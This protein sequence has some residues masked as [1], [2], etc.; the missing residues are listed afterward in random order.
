[1]QYFIVAKKSTTCRLASLVCLALVFCA[2]LI[3]IDVFAQDLRCAFCG[4]PIAPNTR[5]IRSGSNTFCSDACFNAWAAKSAQRCVVCGNPIT[6]GY[7]KDGK[8]YCSMKC[9]STTFPK[10]VVC[11]KRSIKGVLIEGD[12]SKFVCQE[13]AQK[14]KC[15]SCGMPGDTKRMDDGRFI[16]QTCAK[17]AIYNYSNAEEIFN[18]VRTLLREKLELSTKHPIVMSLVGLDRLSKMSG[19]SPGEGMEMGLFDYSGILETHVTGEMDSHGNMRKL[20]ES[21]QRVDES[22]KI[23]VLYGLPEARLGEVF[24]HELAHDWMQEFCPNI[25]DLKLKEG[26]AEYIAWKMNSIMGNSSLNS[27]IEKNPDPIY[28]DGFRMM[29]KIAD[30]DGFDGLKLYLHKVS[31]SRAT[32]P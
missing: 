11:G 14:P 28:G 32:A 20:N 10:C 7:T 16:C 27:R 25:K 6:D 9:L 18:S 22:W 5:F 17:T 3:F 23:L 13:C 24:A 30:R 29:K 26:W 19:K 21:S 31:A 12:P 4:K 15:F 2:M 8:V 1:M